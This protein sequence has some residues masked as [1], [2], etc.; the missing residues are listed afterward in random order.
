MIKPMPTFRERIHKALREGPCNGQGELG[1][2]MGLNSLSE[3]NDLAN[4]IRSMLL[5]P[6]EIKETK[7]QLPGTGHEHPAVFDYIYENL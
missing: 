2:R 1:R 5:P 7:R 6:V 4:T 3:W